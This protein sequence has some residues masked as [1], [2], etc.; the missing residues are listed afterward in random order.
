MISFE[1][2]DY[3]GYTREELARNNEIIKWVDRF[4]W[5][6]LAVAGWKELFSQTIN[7]PVILDAID[8]AEKNL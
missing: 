1:L 4:P 2:A 7:N 8:A 6:H 3:N 5:F